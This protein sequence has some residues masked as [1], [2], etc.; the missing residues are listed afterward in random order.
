MFLLK[1]RLI[2]LNKYNIA[3][4]N[5]VLG[6]KSN[7]GSRFKSPWH[8]KITQ[9][10]KYFFK[11]SGRRDLNSWSLDPKSSA[12][13]KL[14]Y[15]PS[16]YFHSFTHFHL[17]WDKGMARLTGVEPVTPTFVVWY[18]IQLSYRRVVKRSIILSKWRRISSVFIL[19]EVPVR[20]EPTL[21]E[22]QSIALPLGYGT[23]GN[24]LITQSS[25]SQ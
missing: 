8:K 17:I 22:L 10:V 14:R 23:S 5:D 9:W 6:A 13:T 24:Y 16:R 2:L 3:S 1:H 7:K 15:A 21:I 25:K 4:K 20:V 19:L 18:S 11:W 12:V